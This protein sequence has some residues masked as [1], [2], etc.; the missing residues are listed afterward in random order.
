MLTN[1]GLLVVNQYLTNAIPS[2]AGSIGIGLLSSS[3]TTASTQFLQYEVVRVPVT[4]K[5]YRTV[6]GSNQ[7]VLKATLNP[8]SVFKAYEIG[9]YPMTVNVGSFMDN[10]QISTFTENYSGSSLWFN[11]NT[12]SPATWITSSSADTRPRI[13][14]AMVAVS[15]GSTVF[16][17]G[18]QSSSVSYTTMS[19]STKA[20]NSYDYIDVLFSCA[21]AMSGTASIT[22]TLGDDTSLS[23]N[24]WVATGSVATVPTGSFSTARLSFSAKPTSFTDNVVSASVRFHNLTS[25]VILLDMLKFVMGNYKTNDYQLVARTTSSDPNVPLFTKTYGQPMDIEYYIQVT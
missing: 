22:V 4:L 9:V 15:A 16:Y 25:G 3:A 17:P 23:P 5:S 20:F 8:E 13:S 11:L 18:T 10:Y 14:S 12:L 1:N 7:I 21:S 19:L 24:C 2:W 6:S